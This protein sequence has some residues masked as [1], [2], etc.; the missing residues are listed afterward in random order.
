MKVNLKRSG[1]LFPGLAVDVNIDSNTL[2]KNK[3][4]QLEN[5]VNSLEKKDDAEKSAKAPDEFQ[6][7]LTIK[8]DKQ[9]NKFKTSDT[10]ASPEMLQLID[11]LIETDSRQ[12]EK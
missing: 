12:K 1:G 10:S 8:D 6:Y 9:T 2:E 7:E 4:E 11:W 3:A 5:M